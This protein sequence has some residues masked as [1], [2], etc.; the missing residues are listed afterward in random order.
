MSHIRPLRICPLPRQKLRTNWHS[1]AQIS[2]SENGDIAKIGGLLAD[3]TFAAQG[4]RAGAIR[5][6]FSRIA[7]VRIRIACSG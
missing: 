2:H 4:T 3:V 1:G 5:V 7:A 6:R